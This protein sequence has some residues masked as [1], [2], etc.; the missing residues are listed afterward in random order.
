MKDP[1]DLR[2]QLDAAVRVLDELY[3]SLG[4]K[5]PVSSIYLKENIAQAQL[6]LGAALF[7][8]DCITGEVEAFHASLPKT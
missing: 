2:R 5:R 1:A 7:Q 8:L 6:H 4:M 3:A